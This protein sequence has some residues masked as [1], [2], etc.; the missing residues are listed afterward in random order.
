MHLLFFVLSRIKR[1]NVSNES[2]WNSSVCFV[3]CWSWT[4][5]LLEDKGIKYGE[6]NMRVQAQIKAAVIWF[7]INI[8]MRIMS[9]AELNLRYYKKTLNIINH[10]SRYRPTAACL[11]A[12]SLLSMQAFSLGQPQEMC[13]CSCHRCHIWPQMMQTSYKCASWHFRQISRSQRILLSKPQS[14]WLSVWSHE[15]GYFRWLLA[16]HERQCE[17]KKSGRRAKTFGL[18]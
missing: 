17:K 2:E 12:R 1:G 13:V 16:T 18:I 7:R 6:K 4:V 5:E 9:G 11:D 15:S 3:S 10:V 8:L 14:L